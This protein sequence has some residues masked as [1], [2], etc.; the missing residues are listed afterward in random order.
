[1]TP[2]YVGRA[3]LATLQGHDP[4]RTVPALALRRKYDELTGEYTSYRDL[5]SITVEQ[6][7]PTLQIRQETPHGEQ[8]VPLFP[9]SVAPDDYSFYSVS[10]SG[11]R[12]AAEFHVDDGVDLVCQRLKYRKV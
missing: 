8:L 5:M 11:F 10:K 4:E 7:G 12:Q 2:Q 1:M 6:E 9:E 3:L